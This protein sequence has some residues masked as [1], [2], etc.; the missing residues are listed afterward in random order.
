MMLTDPKHWVLFLI[1]A[2]LLVWVVFVA[3]RD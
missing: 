2:L 1:M 3:G